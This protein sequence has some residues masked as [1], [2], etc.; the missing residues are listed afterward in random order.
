MDKKLEYTIS[1]NEGDEAIP[2]MC[3]IKVSNRVPGGWHLAYLEKISPKL[4][5][6][7]P[8]AIEFN[9]DMIPDLIKA[10]QEIYDEEKV[11]EVA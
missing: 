6:D 1:I 7:S 4:L 3:A 5:N 8:Q 2:K 9:Y 11:P 10:L